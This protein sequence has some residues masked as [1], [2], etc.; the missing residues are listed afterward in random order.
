MDVSVFRRWFLL[1]CVRFGVSSRILQ[2]K[3]NIQES[4]ATRKCVSNFELFDKKNPK[5]IPN[6]L[7]WLSYV[8]PSFGIILCSCLFWLVFLCSEI[9]IYLPYCT[10]FY[11]TKLIARNVDEISTKAVNHLLSYYSNF[12][13][14]MIGYI[15]KRKH[16]YNTSCKY[17]HLYTFIS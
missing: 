16:A 15:A 1:Q 11:S 4:C 14:L 17:I 2:A 13:L 9:Y 8:F 10:T 3:N 5:M 7:I 12:I 6:V